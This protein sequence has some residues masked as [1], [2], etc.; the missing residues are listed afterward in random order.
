MFRRVM[1]V[2]L[3]ALF[4]LAGIQLFRPVKTNP[5][6]RSSHEINATAAD[7]EVARVLFRSCND[8]HSNRTTW[9]WY[10]SVAPVS[11]LVVSDVN[12]GRAALNFSEWGAYRAEAQREHLSEIC[13]EVSEGEMPGFSYTLMHRDAKLSK[14]EVAAVCRWTQTTAQT[15]LTNETRKEAFEE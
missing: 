6:I 13:K 11:W 15:L 12:R 5:P 8:C 4:L 9:P 7:P 1:Y 3:P 2:I 10:S 14:A